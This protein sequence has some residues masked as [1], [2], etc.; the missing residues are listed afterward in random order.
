MTA[1]SLIKLIS[2]QGDFLLTLACALGESLVCI[3]IL[4]QG[5]W[6]KFPMF[7]IFLGWAFVVDV[8]ALYFQHRLSDHDYF[9]F[10][11]RQMIVDSALQ[12]A[13]LVELSWAVL[14]PVR[15]SLPRATIV[16]LTVLIGLAGLVIWPLAI[17]TAVPQGYVKWSAVVFHLQQTIGILRILCFLIMAAFSQVLSIGW[18]DRE[19]QIATGLGFFSIVSL[20]VTLTHSQ[21]SGSDIDAF[22]WLDQLVSAGYLGTLSY[23]VLS[24]ATQEQKRKEFSP[25]MQHLLLQLGGG[26]RAG[27]IALS[28]LPPEPS[29][30]KD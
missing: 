18:R 23:W 11:L 17:K 13:V 28:D 1:D 24:F 7:S 26:V 16:V 30:N 25:Q 19:L 20:M 4:R 3:F 12:F 27:R 2:S 9:Q 21:Q 22:H 10:Y 14:R 8:A 5:L 15:T 6:R 29:R